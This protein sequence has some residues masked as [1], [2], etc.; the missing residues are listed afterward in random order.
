VCNTLRGCLAHNDRARW[1]WPSS[2][3]STES[4]L[5]P[6]R[7]PNRGSRRPASRCSITTLRQGQCRY[8]RRF[9]SR[10]PISRGG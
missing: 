9:V 2:G 4:P 7:F 3:C 8:R 1:C 10:R 6:T 5:A